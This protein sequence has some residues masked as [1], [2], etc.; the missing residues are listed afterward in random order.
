M[1]LCLRCNGPVWGRPTPTAHYCIEC[2]RARQTDP[3]ARSAIKRHKVFQRLAHAM[4]TA[5][6]RYGD[7]PSLRDGSTQCA[8]CG[9]PAS[10]YDHRDYLKPLEVEAVCRVCNERRGPAIQGPNRKAA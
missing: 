2:L 1:K 8:D 7:L 9:K 10:E 4:V 5:A 6:I 3:A